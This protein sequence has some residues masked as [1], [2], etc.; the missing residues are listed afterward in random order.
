[1]CEPATIGYA[2]AALVGGYAATKAMTPKVPTPQATAPTAPPAPPPTPSVAPTAAVQQAAK[3]P[4]IKPMRAA[5][6]MGS[7][8]NAGPSSTFLTGPTGVDLGTLQIGKN[9]LLG[10]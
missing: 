9:T 3:Q 10:Q 4:E 2:A 7:G 6:A 5:N 8:V 1:M